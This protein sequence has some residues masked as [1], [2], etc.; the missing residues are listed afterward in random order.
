L[1][2]PGQEQLVRLIYQGHLLRDDGQTL[3]ALHLAPNSVVHCHL[4]QRRPPSADPAA[5]EGARTEGEASRAAPLN[6]GTLMMPLLVL[7]LAALW[8]VQLQHRH[9][10]TATA[11]TCLTGLT[12]LFSCVA[13]AVYRR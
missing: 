3:A 11:T 10:F 7:L 4:S 2:F 6:V 9:V 5:A 8:Y 1:C 13:F 12:L